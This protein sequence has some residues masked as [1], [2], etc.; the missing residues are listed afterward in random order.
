ML[1]LVKTS[2]TCLLFEMYM[3]GF[4]Y[5]KP[6]IPI[7][8]TKIFQ[9]LIATAL[10][11]ALFDFITICTVNHRDIV[12]EFVN[13]G[14][15]VIYLMSILGF[16]Y[17]LFLYMRSY[18]ETSLKFTKAIRI[19]HSLPFFISTVGIFVLPIT[20]VHGKTTDYS[21]GP[22]AYALYGSLVIYLILQLY[23][24]L[25]YWKIL[26]GEKRVAIVIAV[27]LYIIT[28]VLQM[29]IPET[30]VVVVCTTLILLGLILS[31]ENTE[32]YVDERTTL[33]NQYSFEK[34]L[35]EYDFDKQKLII[36]VLCFCK[37]ENSLD[38]KQDVLILNDVR[39]EIKQ[40]RL[41]GYRVCENGV[42]FIS[43]TKEKAGM[44][45]EKVRRSLEDKY[46]KENISIET[47]ILTGDATAT[48]Y[49]CMRNIVAFSAEVG[50]RL[51]Y[52]DYL[53]NI[54]NRNAL[55]RDL[56]KCQEERNICYF[57]ADINNL[58]IVNDTMGHSA[59]DK[60][61]QGFACLLADAV[62]TD[63]RAYRQGGDEFAVLYGKD[64]QYFMGKLEGLCR[65]YN[66]SSTVPISYAIGYCG[67]ENEKFR[68][69]A[70]QMMYAD[71]K[72]KKQLK[73]GKSL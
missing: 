30:L 51:A 15:H 2:I 67:I 28:A 14:M 68:D 32:K 58:K 33:F 26:D 18:L 50:S 54:H 34:V 47:K 25:R 3:I 8:S 63:G 31:N 40:Y 72:Q 35:E 48:K 66:K 38:W 12:P 7:K 21:L 44:V 56:D 39:K 52:I 1:V 24:C 37:I 41:Y 55:E 53:T 61:L 13:L 6:H 60:L 42:V 69:I 64:A 23:Y 19:F 45:L 10:M 70:D 20:Y 36:A 49:S 27:P 11:N 22:K 29:M 4:Y 9:W 46:G 62:G 65:D 5:R 57:I 17:L 43:N 73:Q 16:I 71:K 59:G